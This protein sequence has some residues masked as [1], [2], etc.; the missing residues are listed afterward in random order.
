MKKNWNSDMRWWRKKMITFTE[1]ILNFKTSQMTSKFSSFLLDWCDLNVFLNSAIVLVW[2][3]DPLS[4]LV[5]HQAV[6]SSVTHSF[7]QLW[8]SR[9]F[10]SLNLFPSHLFAFA[11]FIQMPTFRPQSF[12]KASRWYFITFYVAIKSRHRN[13]RRGNLAVVT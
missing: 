3:S 5:P 4:Y 13:R 11:F 12:T 9:D 10:L 6:A 1:N 7:P 8:S 2:A